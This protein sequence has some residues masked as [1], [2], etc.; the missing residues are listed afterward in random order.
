MPDTNRPLRVMSVLPSMVHGGAERVVARLSTQLSVLG[1]C[2]SIVMLREE[3]VFYEMDPSVE[4]FSAVPKRMAHANK[5]LAG[6]M[7]LVS[8]VRHGRRWRPDV[9]IG[10]MTYSAV[11]TTLAARAVGARAIV[12]ERVSPALWDRH[13]LSLRMLRNRMYKMCDGFIAQTAAASEAA[14]RWLP[15]ERIRV[16][17]NPARAI[18]AYPAVPREKIVL[19]VARLDRKKRQ[20]ELIETFAALNAPEWKLAI[21]GDGKLRV[22]LEATVR[23][24]GVESKVILAGAVADVDHWLA[25]SAIFV[26]SSESEGLPNALIEAMSAGMACISYDCETG[27]RE[28]IRHGENGMLVP[29]GDTG[30]LAAAL[31]RLMVDPAWRNTLGAEAKKIAERLDHGLIARQLQ[32][33]CRELTVLKGRK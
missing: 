21:L 10:V 9:M 6:M 17:P 11:M 19:N 29:V 31:Q 16:I 12:A 3:T 26:L 1:N 30:A 20:K 7:Q 23:K 15:A 5:V 13:G 8:L 22:E 27:P 14:K 2:C 33:F 25:R 32:L 18:T 24:L 28:L 4:L